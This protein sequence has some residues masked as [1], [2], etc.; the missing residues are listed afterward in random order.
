MNEPTE[1]SSPL[2]V[3]RSLF[4]ELSGLFTKIP[5]LGNFANFPNV[6]FCVYIAKRYFYVTLLTLLTPNSAAV[7]ILLRVRR[8]RR[9][10]SFCVF[11]LHARMNAHVYIAKGLFM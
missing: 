7:E 4:T 9:V 8:V 5:P 3:V 2:T 10:T 11:L 6:S 1:I